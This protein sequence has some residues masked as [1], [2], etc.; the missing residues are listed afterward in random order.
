MEKFNWTETLMDLLQINL[1]FIGAL[2]L[3]CFG[4]FI[5]ILKR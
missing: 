4:L 2:Y 3:I 1:M 5:Y